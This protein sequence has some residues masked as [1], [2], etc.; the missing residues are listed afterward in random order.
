[1]P[2][3]PP[4]HPSQRLGHRPAEQWRRLPAE[5]RQGPPP[6]WPL[7]AA[8]NAAELAVWATLWATPQAVVWD[9]LR[10]E[11]LVARY[12]LHLVAVEVR[13][14]STRLLAEVRQMEAQLLLAPGSLAKARMEIARDE[15]AE[16]RERPA[17]ADSG[18]TARRRLMAVDGAVARA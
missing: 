7:A 4:K 10:A 2:G 13:S 6:A 17:V 14:P 1:M 9:E 18:A 3:P 11:R 5:G 8:P 15:V 16:Q 12:V